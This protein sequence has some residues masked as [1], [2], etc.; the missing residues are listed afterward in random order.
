MKVLSCDNCGGAL[1]PVGGKYGNVL[2]CP[3]CGSQHYLE[4]QMQRFI[5]VGG[6]HFQ[7]FLREAIIECFSLQDLKL[8]CDDV[9]SLTRQ[10]DYEDIG[11]GS[12]SGKVL[13]MVQYARRRGLLLLLTELFMRRNRQFALM[14]DNYNE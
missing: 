8:V 7:I 14:V 13:E 5:L 3:Y 4:N 9:Y 1:D 11:G 6:N 12:K 2:T 10:M